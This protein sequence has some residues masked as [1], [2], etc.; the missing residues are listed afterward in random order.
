MLGLALDLRD[1]FGCMGVVVDAKSGA[2]G[3]YES[4][5]FLKLDVT[6]GDLSD[7]PGPIP[8]FLAVNRDSASWSKVRSRKRVSGFFRAAAS[9][10]SFCGESGQRD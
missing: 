9:N 7:R 3:F 2:V 4:L 6:S 10:K 8:M 5:G 1:R